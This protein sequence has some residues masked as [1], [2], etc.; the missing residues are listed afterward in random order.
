MRLLL[1]ATDARLQ[2]GEFG[3]R[4]GVRT[5]VLEAAGEEAAG[6]AGRIEHGL[7]EPRVDHV[8]GELRGGTRCVELAGVTGALEIL[9]DL[10]VDVP[11][12]VAGLRFVE[13]DVVVDLVDHLPHQRA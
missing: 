4:V 13:V 6:A 10:L 5:H 1:H 3:G 12:G 9:E 8:A 11:E 2:R 7:A